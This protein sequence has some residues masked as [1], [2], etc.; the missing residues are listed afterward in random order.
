MN[1]MTLKL[2]ECFGSHMVLQRDTLVSIWGKAIAGQEVTICFQGKKFTQ[3]A[4]DK[5]DFTLKIGPFEVDNGSDLQVYTA[6]KK[7]TLSDVAVGEVWLCA[8]QSN[9]EFPMGYDHELAKEINDLPQN[10]RY[11]DY[12]ELAY[13]GEI[14]DADYHH[15]GFWRKATEH[16]LK[17]FTAVG[18]YFAKRLSQSMPNV[19]IGLL[20]CNWGGTLISCWMDK[21][22]LFKAGAQNIWQ[23]YQDQIKDLNVEQY[24]IRFKKRNSNFRTTVFENKVVNWIMT[25]VSMSEIDKRLE[26]EGKKREPWV[27]QPIGPYY[28]WRPCGLYHTMLLHVAPFTVKG[29]LWY[30]GESDANYATQY[31][32]QLVQLIE[33]WREVFQNKNLPFLIVQLAP[34]IHQFGDWGNNWP[35]IRNAQQ[36]VVDHISNTALAVI[37]DSGMKWNIHPIHKRNVGTRLALQ[38][39]NKIYRQNIPC[40][41]PRLKDALLDVKKQEL[42]LKFDNCYQGLVLKDKCE[43]IDGVTMLQAGIIYDHIPV[44]KIEQ[45]VV[46]LNM[47]GFNLNK[48]MTVN[49][50]E[51]DY[52]CM[53][54]VNSV[55]LPARPGKIEVKNAIS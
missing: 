53:N 6:E 22:H 28:E 15:F 51:I 26:K 40:E 47:Q 46:V 55:G 18:Y 17:Y 5:G 10:I 37:D 7:V 44:K 35:I 23:D 32:E 27:P 21:E 16:D 30:Q 42:T 39:L 19:P 43:F 11:F 50:A 13:E 9:M 33:N 49:V 48:S 54:L 1:A 41:A 31:R 8:G 45:S 24:K 12:P 34:F 20:A 4:D 52:C 14:H 38:A 36:W 29:V 2:N 3:K 25:N